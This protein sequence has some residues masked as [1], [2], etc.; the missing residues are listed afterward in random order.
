VLFAFDNAII[1]FPLDCGIPLIY[2]NYLILQHKYSFVLQ[3][4][5]LV[6]HYS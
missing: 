5:V 6:V 2:N 4:N 3:A 1:V